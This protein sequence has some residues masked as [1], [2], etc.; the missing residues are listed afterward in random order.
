MHAQ[1]DLDSITDVHLK[2]LIVDHLP[3]NHIQH[4][5]VGI[6]RFFHNSLLEL[7]EVVGISSTPI[8]AGPILIKKQ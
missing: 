1:T 2:M 5:S 3:V 7:L 6:C 4:R 8:I